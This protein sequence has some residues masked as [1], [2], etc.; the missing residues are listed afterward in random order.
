M[1]KEKIRGRFK[2]APWYIKDDSVEV[3]IGGAGGIGSWLSF[4]IARAGFQVTLYDFDQIEI[5]NMGGQ[6]FNI[7]Q[8]GTY[9][10]DAIAQLISKFSSVDI[11]VIKEKYV[12]ESF[13]H[14][15]MFSAFDNMEARKVM[16]NNWKVVAEQNPTSIFIDG[17]LLMEQMQIFCVT[18][19][20]AEEYEKEHLFNDSEVP[21][22]NCTM[23]QTS[24]SASLIASLMV[25]FFTN[26][27]TN[28]LQ[29]SKG[30]Q[31][32][33]LHEYFIPINL[34]S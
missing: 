21:D 9:K 4:L 30:R 34:T 16:F 7:D 23:K 3:I 33:F 20:T 2:D 18:P 19:E 5:H 10:V 11:N 12:E 17:R 29:E 15:Y 13:A 26:H 14:L 31:V 25:G 28:V 6:L 1:E 24:H 27:I 22:E 8:V 32:P